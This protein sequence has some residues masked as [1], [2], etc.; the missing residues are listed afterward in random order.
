[1]TAEVPEAQAGQELRRRVRQEPA[2]ADGEPSGDDTLV[3]ELLVSQQVQSNLSDHV[4][5]FSRR[6]NNGAH[7]LWVKSDGSIIRGSSPLPFRGLK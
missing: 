6:R 1:M 4:Q 2:E 3:P 5:N 7:W